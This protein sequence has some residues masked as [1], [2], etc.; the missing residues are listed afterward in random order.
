MLNPVATDFVLKIAVAT[1]CG[2]LHRSERRKS[3]TAIFD[4]ADRSAAGRYRLLTHRRSTR[5]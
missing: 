4:R 3:A 1:R 2:M 5:R